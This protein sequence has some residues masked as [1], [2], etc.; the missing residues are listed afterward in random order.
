MIHL[1]PMQADDAP[2]VLDIWRA[3]VNATHDFLAP[4]DFAAIEQ[5]LCAT[6]PQVPLTLATHEN[7]TILGF[8]WLHA[9]HM[10]ALFVDPAHHETGIGRFLV[11][12]ALR[13]HPTLTTTVNAQNI[14]ATR[15]YEHLGFTAFARSEQDEQ[16]RPYPL[17]HLRHTPPA[18][19]KTAMAVQ[20]HHKML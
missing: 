12:H 3:A 2:R 10:E 20:C 13:L 14:A 11:R 7:G 8:M 4:Q 5:E 6:L 1:R 19:V 9:G 17:L 18:E 16:G 15:F